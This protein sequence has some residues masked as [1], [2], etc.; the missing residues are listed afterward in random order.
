MAQ[1]QSRPR[2][3]ALCP[4]AKADLERRTLMASLN[5][6]ASGA[7]CLMAF[8]QHHLTGT[9]GLHQLLSI[10]LLP[11]AIS[12]SKALQPNHIQDVI[13]NLRN[14]VLEKMYHYLSIKWILRLQE[15]LNASMFGRKKP[16]PS[17]LVVN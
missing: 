6:P 10:G 8:L 2:S 5:D 13:H 9:S 12:L 17:G 14:P 7:K 1:V 11:F 4:P 16:K 3:P 15:L